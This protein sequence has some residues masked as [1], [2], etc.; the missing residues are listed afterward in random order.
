MSQASASKAGGD[1]RR[2][3]EPS[4][5]LQHKGDEPFRAPHILLIPLA[6]VL[7]ED[8]LFHADTVAEADQRTSHKDQQ[9]QPVGIAEPKS[10]Q[11]DEQAGIGGMT[12]ESVGTR[13]DHGL[14]GCDC[15]RRREGGAEH[16]DCVETQ[17]D[18]HIDQKNAQ[19][20]EDF[21]SARDGGSR[22]RKKNGRNSC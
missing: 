13:F 8:A 4:I 22:N 19:P 1:A 16:V 10:E 17:R 6:Q 7:L 5:P 20:E 15:H 18:P 3:M 12:N 2:A 9:T 14:L 11:R 21:A